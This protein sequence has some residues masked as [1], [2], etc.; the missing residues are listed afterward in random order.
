VVIEP[1]IFGIQDLDPNDM[2]LRHASRFNFES[3]I[4]MHYMVI[5]SMSRNPQFHAYLFCFGAI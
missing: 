2:P 3:L 5:G 1:S 4:E